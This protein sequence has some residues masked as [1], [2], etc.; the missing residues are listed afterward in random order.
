MKTS[1]FQDIDLF[2]KRKFIYLSYWV[3]RL[4]MAIT[5]ILSGAR[6]LPGIKFTNLPLDNPVG[7]YFEAM[8]TTGFYWNFIGYFQIL[9]G[10]LL[11]FNRFVVLSILLMMPVTFNIFLI[12]W[13]LNMMGTPIITSLMLLA[14]SFLMFWHRKNYKAILEKPIV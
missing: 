11:I 13:S 6:K 1:L 10:L 14:N 8:Y 9:I 7:L 12:S 5:F 3:I 4:G 2:K